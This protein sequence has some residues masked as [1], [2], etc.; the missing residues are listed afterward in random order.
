MKCSPLS[1]EELEAAACREQSSDRRPTRESGLGLD[2]DLAGPGHSERVRRIVDSRRRPPIRASA[3]PESCQN[4]RSRRHDLEPVENRHVHQRQ[5]LLRRPFGH[6]QGPA[7]GS[8]GSTPSRRQLHLHR[9]RHGWFPTRTRRPITAPSQR[10]FDNM[11]GEIGRGL[12]ARIRPAAQLD[13]ERDR[14][15]SSTAIESRAR[16]MPTSKRSASR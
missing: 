15:R 4:R 5:V 7:G 10:I 12:G 11:V 9:A 3:Q 2:P 16:S 6:A 8:P 14:R 1:V 13:G